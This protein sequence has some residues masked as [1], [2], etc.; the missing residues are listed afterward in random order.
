MDRD[1]EDAMLEYLLGWLSKLEMS[2]R[3]GWN[4]AQLALVRRML[5]DDFGVDYDAI[6]PMF[7]PKTP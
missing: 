3:T 4:K 5:I 1:T 2:E 7:E 6:A